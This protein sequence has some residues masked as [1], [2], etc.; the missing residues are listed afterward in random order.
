MIMK[1]TL[2][3]LPLAALLAF[4]APASADDMRSALREGYGRIVFD[5]NQPVRYA[6]EVVGG[7]LLIQFERPVTGDITK[8]TQSLAAYVNGG[9]LSQLLGKI[10]AQAARS[11]HAPRLTIRPDS[12]AS[13][14]NWAGDTKPSRGCR[15][16][17]RASAPVMRPLS[18]WGW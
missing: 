4:S 12:S 17:N 15:Q 5:W 11:T 16:R 3:L 6:A 13:G 2:S 7:T 9:R 18:T 10:S 1:R 14:M 8:I